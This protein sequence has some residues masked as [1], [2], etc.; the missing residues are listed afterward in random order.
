MENLTQSILNLINHLKINNIILK[1][2][3][4]ELES[5]SFYEMVIW[6]KNVLKE[7]YPKTKLK[8]MM[9][10]IHYANNFENENL[11]Q[12]AYTLD[13]IEQYLTINKFL[14]HDCSVEFFNNKITTKD[15]VI[16]PE[17]LIKTCIESLM[18]AKNT[19]LKQ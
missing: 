13:E 10:S 9:K 2:D 4:N 7:Q 18:L 1:Y 15:F 11:K 16:T 6:L 12:S 3:I 19:N 8:P 14:N 17:N 5:K